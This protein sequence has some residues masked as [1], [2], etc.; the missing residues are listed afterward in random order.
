MF[1]NT[2]C[3]K[4]FALSKGVIQLYSITVSHIESLPSQQSD[5]KTSLLTDPC[6]IGQFLFLF[7]K[8]YV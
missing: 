4:A 6:V 3:P 5:F 7:K 2:N 8:I 1:S